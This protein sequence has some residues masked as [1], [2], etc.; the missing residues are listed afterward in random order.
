MKIASKSDGRFREVVMPRYLS[1][2]S[3]PV[4]ICCY[5][6]GARFAFVNYDKITESACAECLTP[7]FLPPE[8]E[9]L[10][11]QLEASN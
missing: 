2:E 5:Q 4:V 3:E 7:L 10:A 8:L 11:R 9:G 6:C 1:V